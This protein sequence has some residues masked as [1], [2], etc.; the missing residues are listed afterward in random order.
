MQVI[1][2]SVYSHFL[3]HHLSQMKSIGG[4]QFMFRGIARAPT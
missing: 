4:S 3:G 1:V 2:V